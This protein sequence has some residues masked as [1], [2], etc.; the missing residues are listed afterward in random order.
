MNVAYLFTFFLVVLII[1]FLLLPF[2]RRGKSTF[3][4]DTTTPKVDDSIPEE[5]ALDLGREDVASE[6]L[7]N[8]PIKSSQAS[9]LA[10]YDMEIEVAVKRARLRK[11]TFSQCPQCGHRVQSADRF[12]A[13]CGKPVNHHETI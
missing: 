1:L 13:S 4:A 3:E 10:E 5:I 2:V 9:I 8:L 6:E 7:D 11:S 12:C